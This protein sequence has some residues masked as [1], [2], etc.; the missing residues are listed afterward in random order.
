MKIFGILCVVV[1]LLMPVMAQ[2]ERG[3]DDLWPSWSP[4]GTRIA[5]ISDRDG[6]RQIYVMNA[7]GSDLRALARGSSINWTTFWSPDGQTLTYSMISNGAAD[8]YQVDVDGG[9]PP[10]NLTNNPLEYGAPLWSPDGVWIAFS[11]RAEGEKLELAL[12]EV[13]TNTV[14]TIPEL[15]AEAWA[16]DWSPDGRYLLV[17]GALDQNGQMGNYLYDVQTKVVIDLLVDYPSPID[18][19]CWILYDWSSDMQWLIFVVG[20]QRD[21]YRLNLETGI[22][23]RIGITPHIVQIFKLTADGQHIVYGSRHRPEDN[24]L[25]NDGIYRINLADKTVET[26]LP[27]PYFYFTMSP[28]R[29]KLLVTQPHTPPEDVAHYFIVDLA[30]GRQTFFDVPLFTGLGNMWS[31]D[32]RYIVASMCS[33]RDSNAEADIYVVDVATGESINLTVDDALLATPL[34]RSECS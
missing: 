16:Y 2:D 28:D 26:I 5:F 15:K 3:A 33:G 1:L 20:A 18:N 32:S 29:S 8:V 25:Q 31:P 19:C 30:S 34:D 9:K 6:Y 24:S 4:D 13:E 7:D 11:T 10:V 23:E 17:W 22:R 27:A 14:Q 21:I 12:L